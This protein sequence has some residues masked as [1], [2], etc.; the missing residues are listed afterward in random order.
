MTDDCKGDNFTIYHIFVISKIMPPNVCC[1][2]IKK[3]TYS[4]KIILKT[5]GSES[6]LNNKVTCYSTGDIKQNKKI[7]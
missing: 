4:L 3:F 5:A 7:K 2:L 6:Q 1:K